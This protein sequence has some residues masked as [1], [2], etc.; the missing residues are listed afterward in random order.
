MERYTF[1]IKL[2]RFAG[3]LLAHCTDY[4]RE[5]RSIET[6]FA[7]RDIN[8]LESYLLF[9]DKGEMAHRIFLQELALAALEE[10]SEET[11]PILERAFHRAVKSEWRCCEGIVR[12]LARLKGA[13]AGPFLLK[14]LEHPS[15]GARYYAAYC[16][17]KVG[18]AE[19]LP[20]L[21]AELS[22][23]RG[24]HQLSSYAFALQ[25]SIEALGSE[26]RA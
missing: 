7:A 17:G 8:K 2:N 3:P 9:S 20:A 14:A 22:A 11:A 18:Y 6:A 24:N 1:S 13:A 4:Q 5:A 15:Y 21:K 19:A 16:I 25:R 12:S 23:V 10:I 26:F